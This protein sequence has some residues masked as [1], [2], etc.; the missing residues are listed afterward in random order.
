MADW[1]TTNLPDQWDA[2]VKKTVEDAQ[3]KN[4]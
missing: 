4:A 2:F 1:Y 3:K